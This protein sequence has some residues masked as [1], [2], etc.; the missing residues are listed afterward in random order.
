MQKTVSNNNVKPNP[1][2]RGE[3]Q[4]VGFVQMDHDLYARARNPYFLLNEAAVITF[5]NAAVLSRSTTGR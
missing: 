3:Q 2:I 4:Y 1:N 5:S